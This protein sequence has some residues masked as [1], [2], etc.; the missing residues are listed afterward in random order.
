MRILYATDGSDNSLAGAQL[1]ASLDL[2]ATDVIAVLSVA[3]GSDSQPAVDAVN[4]AVR[5][6]PTEPTHLETIVRGNHPADEILR[7]ASELPADL[8]VLGARGHSGLATLLSS[9]V[10]DQVLRRAHCPVLLARP[11]PNGLRR[12]LLGTDGSPGAARAA[13][14]LATLPLPAECEIRLL[15]LLPAFEQIARE[16]LA[17]GPPLAPEVTTLAE[18]QRTQAQAH[19]DEVAAALISAGKKVVTEIRGVDP[20]EGL[21]ETANEEGTELIVLGTHT[22][23]RMERFF[24]GS[25]S[26]S[27]AHQARCSVL[28][29]R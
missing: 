23:S 21:L 7:T 14:Y 16:H 15:T 26:E 25:V 11:T 4:S 19:L 22:Q 3:T 12:V 5:R 28:L 2:G 10:S 17:V 8:L 27:L 9:S 20:A 24:L 6:L 13:E 29:V 18:L 1:L